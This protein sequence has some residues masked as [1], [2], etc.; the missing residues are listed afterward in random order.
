MNER[1]PKVMTIHRGRSR[2]GEV[3]L[4][5]VVSICEFAKYLLPGH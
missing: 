1:E 4:S 2:D 5:A 3:T